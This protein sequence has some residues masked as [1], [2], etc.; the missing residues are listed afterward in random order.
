MKIGLKWV[1]MSRYG[2]IIKTG[3]SPMA[4]DHFQTPPDP[5]RGYKNTKKSQ[6]SL[7]VRAKPAKQYGEHG[8]CQDTARA[9]SHL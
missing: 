3:K 7:K 8:A 6:K 4:Q 2:L 1:H 9:A 5:E